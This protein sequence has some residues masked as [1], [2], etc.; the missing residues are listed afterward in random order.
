MAALPGFAG[1]AYEAYS[2]MLA[3]ERCVNLFPAR[4]LSGGQARGALLPVPGTTVFAT[5]GQAPGRAV[6]FDAA[7]QR[8]FA[9]YGSRFYE[10][11]SGGA[12]TERGTVAVDANPATITSNG[13]GGEELLVVSG[14]RGDIF[15]LPTNLYTM[16]VVTGITYG[17]EING[18]FVGLDAPTSTLKMSKS[19]DGLT[20]AGGDVVQR[21]APDP[22]AAMIIVAN[23]IV[24]I[25]QKTGEVWYDAGRSPIPFA[26]RPGTSFEHGIHAPFSLARLGDGCAWLGQDEND[27]G[28]I[29][30]MAGYTP[31]EISSEAIRWAIQQYRDQGL[32][33]SN[34][35][36]WS[37]G[38]EGHRFYVLSFPS[39][40]TSWAYDEASGLW[41]QR[42][43][44]SPPA[45]AFLT[46]RPQFHCVGFGQNLVCDSDGYHLYAFSSSVYTDVGGAA[47]RR[48][49]RVPHPGQ[50]RRR[51]FFPYFELDCDRGVGT[52]AAGQGQDPVV[53]L[54]Y[55]N[56]GGMTWGSDRERKVGKV[57]EYGVR[58]RWDQCGSGRDRQWEL[59]TSDPAASRW[60]DAY[61]PGG[62]G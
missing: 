52:V 40:R 41:S 54:R 10:V 59:W 13:E 5:L 53:V 35:I 61:V 45:D 20:W 17:G 23:E 60:F 48:V 62:R 42:G 37:Y 55:S 47:L 15:A 7:T 57:G 33:T 8:L 1:G 49:R 18:R 25:G 3:G 29:Y 36:G 2:R 30:R 6:F 28:A 39:A 46:Y 14:G 22:W 58:V 16:G 21:T 38:R 43:Y 11:G 27:L 56:D 32:A 50:E 34:A 12:V 51:Q 31:Q 4:V 19:L 9:V 24:L 26:L 44:W